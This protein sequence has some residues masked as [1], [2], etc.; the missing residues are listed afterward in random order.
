[1]ITEVPVLAYY[2]PEK[3]N[4]I[5]SDASLKGIGCVLIQDGRPVCYASRSLTETESRYSNIERELLAACWS[6]EKF[7]HYVFGKNVVIETDNKPLES[8]WKK[9]ITSAS[10]RL[11]RLL[12]RMAK[13]DVDI[14]YI[15][16]RTNV[17]ADALSRVSHM[18]LPPKE[19]EVPLVELDAIT[20]TLPASPAKL[21]EIRQC[22]DQ[23][24]VLA[25]L[26]DVVYHG[27]PEHPT[28]CP[29]DLKEYWNLREDLS[30]ENGL[31]LKGHRLVI[32]SSLRPQMLQRIHQGHLGADT[33]LL[34]A[35][36]AY[37]GQVFHGT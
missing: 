29:Q 14:R 13:Y 3:D 28:E 27:W 34:K 33:C 16:G 32:P 6:P 21:E 12:L 26:K 36:K 19:N 5:Q 22:T 24:V 31:I 30:V 25:H 18:E 2:D 4:L 15:Q 9:T 8:I 37:S 35:K 20:S 10:P 7:N 11:Q 1:M 23:D 17:I